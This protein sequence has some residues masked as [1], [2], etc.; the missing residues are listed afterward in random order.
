MKI[1]NTLT[2]HIMNVLVILIPVLCAGQTPIMKTEKEIADVFLFEK[3]IV[4]YTRKE[5]AGQFL[6]V[7][8]RNS[9]TL[10][11]K[12]SIL[13]K[14]SVNTVVGASQDGTEIFIYHRA[15][16]RNERIVFYSLENK[17][18]IERGE[19]QLPKINN[20]SNNLGLFLSGDKAMLFLSGEFP[21][22]SGY[23]DIY[24]C[25]WR[26]N[27]WSK[28]KNMGKKIN[29]RSPEFAPFVNKDT[30]YFARQERKEAYVYAVPLKESSTPVKL[31][32][33]VNK[34]GSFN[35]YYKKIDH[36]EMWVTQSLNLE[37]IDQAY[38]AFINE[39][40]PIQP[41]QELAKKEP[42]PVQEQVAETKAVEVATPESFQAVVAV[43]EEKKEII[44]TPRQTNKPISADTV[45]LVLQYNFNDPFLDERGI[46]TL[47]QWLVNAE[48]GKQI[49]IK[50][51]ADNRGSA[52][53]NERTSRMRAYFVEWYINRYFKNKNLITST[54]Y[55]VSEQAGAEYCKVELYVTRPKNELV[56]QIE[57]GN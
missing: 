48:P 13:N 23:D 50:G 10:P 33:D 42:D 26:D 41:D 35:A 28:P 3:D 32:N 43:K 53:V 29:T 45:A 11:E 38:T 40:A 51:Y 34:D 15:G 27:E 46:M 24:V 47:T 4:I 21:K 6:Y 49:R 30:L 20:H 39:P 14:G 31:D 18:W 1:Q 12:D 19:R 22:T 25:E 36:K 54:E 52:T 9:K 17:K 55:S 5:E 2:R 57:I 8:H 16:L 37:G 44:S 56:N 7:T